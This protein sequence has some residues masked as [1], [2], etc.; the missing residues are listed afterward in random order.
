M[1][2]APACASGG[3]SPSHLRDCADCRRTAVTIGLDDLALAAARDRGR[4]LRRIA[5]LLPL[6]GFLRR[7][8]EDG[9]AALNSVGPAA[10]EHGASLAGKATAVVVAAALAAGGAGVAT[11]ASGGGLSLPAC[12]GAGPGR[13]ASG[14]GDGDGAGG[15][16]EAAAGR[17]RA[18]DA[19][20]RG[21]CRRGSPAGRSRPRRA[22]PA[23][24]GRGGTPA[25][26]RGDRD[27]G[28]PR[29]RR[30]AQ[31]QSAARGGAWAARSAP[32]ARSAARSARW[33]SL[34]ATIVHRTGDRVTGPVDQ[35]LQDVTGGKAPQTAEGPASRHGMRVP[36]TGGGSSSRSLPDVGG[37]RAAAERAGADAERDR[38]PDWGHR[39]GHAAAPALA[40]DRLRAAQ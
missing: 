29:R 21:G 19:R 23:A 4:A 32:R 27:S 31:A 13:R 28:G 33:W 14:S 30:N 12:L 5:G 24:G 20:R 6:P 22:G 25:T 40:A 1:G 10:A 9:V 15:E 17:A 37:W 35:T 38:A 3:A 7:R 2:C 39:P 18:A 26:C 36:G 16:R 34:P 8:M 11:K